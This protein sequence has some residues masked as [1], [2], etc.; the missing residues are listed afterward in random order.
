M[1]NWFVPIILI[2]LAISG[3]SLAPAYQRP[4]ITIPEQ[5]SMSSAAG[6]MPGK[7]GR[8]F[9]EELGSDELNRVMKVA[10]AQNLDLEAA[11]HRIDQAR[12]QARMAGAPLYP[13]VQAGGATSRTYQEAG[14]ASAARGLGSI[15][16][17]LDLW[18]RNRAQKAAASYRADARQHD[19]EA[20][21]LILSADTAILYTHI[22]ALDE[23]IRISTNNAQNAEEILRIIEARYR[24]GTVSGLEVSQQRV[25]VNNFRATLANLN[26]Q[27]ATALHALAILLGE[28]PKNVPAPQTHLSALSL[29]EVNLTPPADLLTVRPDIA[30][31]ELNLLAANADIGSARAA[32]FPS[33]TLGTDAS[34][35]A[36]LGHP[37]VT[38]LSLASNV[39]API[40][41]GGRLTGNLENITARQKELAAHYQKTV[42]VAF[43][44]VE[45]AL[46]AIRTTTE[47]AALSLDSVKEAHN[48]YAI[49][50]ARFDAG[51]IDYLTLLE[52]QRS[53]Y[54]A[55]DGQ[56]LSN[57]AQLEAF[58]LLRKA[59]G[60]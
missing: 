53:L 40:F 32:F 13:A 11:L 4:Q 48:A 37:A 18:G 52:A 46:A 59:L 35:A 8:P 38:A 39:L 14:D 43:R 57:A 3:C 20:L 60:S 30:G 12:A 42:L 50:R 19:F 45:D 6:Y 16:Y 47:Q 7:N 56:I 44:E 17:E 41:S 36:A 49:A 27:R 2:S 26:E 34:I 21:R 33:L 24:A 15:S 54:Q 10:L 25:I 51:A 28:T 31:A 1:R 29:P 55:E 58:V 23:R 9:W 22:L 5:W